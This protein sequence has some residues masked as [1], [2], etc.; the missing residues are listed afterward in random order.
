M[1]DQSCQDLE[2]I[3]CLMED[4]QKCVTELWQMKCPKLQNLEI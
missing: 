4:P 1:G 3:K 2:N